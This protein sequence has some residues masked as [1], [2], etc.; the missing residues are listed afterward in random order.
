MN[1]GVNIDHVATLRQARGTH[2]PDPIAA[3]QACIAAGADGITAHLREDR[4]HIVDADM[5]QLA[6]MELHLNM[7]MAA[8]D[9]MVAIACHLKPA[10]CCLVP[11][12]REE[13]TTE[14]GLDVCSHQS[15][16][17]D[18]VAQLRS[19][20]SRVSMFI[21][22][23]YAQIEACVAI[24]APVIEIHTG[25]YANL[26]GAAQLQ[27]LEIIT[28]AAN[29]AKSLGLIVHAGH[30]LTLENTPAIV[31]IDAIE[32]LNIGHAIVADAIFK[33]LHQSVRDF[34]SIMVR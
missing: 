23:D 1:L 22:P 2:Y 15:R 14:G 3:A 21:D 27:E 34:K 33:G 10:A 20:G 18:V 7:E 31:A 12:K 29:Y 11:E 28:N 26:S 9:A 13:L 5:E 8:T 32:E 4:R 19:S 24:H 17:H 30:G 25:H 16:L 6:T